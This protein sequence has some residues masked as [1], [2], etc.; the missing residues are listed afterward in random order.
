M[1]ALLELDDVQRYFGGVKAVDGVSGQLGEGEI[2]GLI[3]PN[4][5]GKTTLL[6]LISAVF[7][8]T[9]GRMRF[10]GADMHGWSPLRA[11]HAGIGRVFQVP[12]LMVDLTV[13]ENV[14]IG[15]LFGSRRWGQS[16]AAQAARDALEMVGLAAKAEAKCGVL[17]GSERKSL[18]LARAIAAGPRLALVDEVMAGKSVSE[19]RQTEDVLLKLKE[20]G[21]S[22]IVVEHVPGVVA[23]IADQICVL[24][25]GK[26]LKWGQPTE[27]MSDAMVIAA[28]LG[29]HH[30]V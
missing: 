4:G 2:L 13:L 9:G 14:T 26:V 10:G 19:V 29:S 24:H 16:A 8:P 25:H 12:Q 6:N 21:T 27:V 30:V 7:K 1:T 11:A 22:L 15:A 17:S 23:N 18:E 3:G 5:S 20:M 28:Y